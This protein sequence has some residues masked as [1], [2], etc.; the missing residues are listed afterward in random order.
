MCG[1]NTMARWMKMLQTTKCSAIMRNKWIWKWN[2]NFPPLLIHYITNNYNSNIRR[3]A[4]K[5][6]VAMSRAIRTYAHWKA[7]W[8]TIIS[9]CFPLLLFNECDFLYVVTSKRE[10]SMEVHLTRNCSTKVNLDS[11][12]NR[13]HFKCLWARNNSIF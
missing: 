8:N 4:G 1:A 3:R 2:C 12:A 10:I 9:R 11:T 5:Q 6:N 7:L 13:F